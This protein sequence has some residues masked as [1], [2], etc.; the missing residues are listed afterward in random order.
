MSKIVL[1]STRYDL[2]GASLLAAGIAAQLRDRGHDAEAW[3]LYFH[4]ER[5]E[6]PEP[7]TRTF[8]PHEP[9][10]VLDL[11]KMT[12]HLAA[13]MRRFRPDAFFG[14]QPLANILGAFTAIAARCPR[15]YGGQHNPADSQRRTLRALEKLIGSLVYTGNI[16]VSE[17]VRTTY[18]DYPAVYRSKMQVIYNGIPPRGPKQP[19]HDARA[20]LGLP[21]DS[22]LIGTVGQHDTDQKNHDF[23]IDLLPR[24]P[25]VHLVIA[26]DGR[27]H[28][29]LLQKA[30]ALGVAD[31]AHL[32]GSV[33][34]RSVEAVLDALD[35]FVFPSRFE[36]FSL[37][38]LEA[39]Q[40]EL[41]VIGND[42]TMIREA[43]SAGDERYGF[44]IP[45]SDPERWSKAILSLK[46]HPQLQESWSRRAAEGA[47]RFS[48]EKMIRSYE[49]ACI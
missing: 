17:A 38:L 2:G 8:L 4:S 22:F 9:R 44:L 23:L 31:R 40:S 26:G 18:L 11:V 33:S 46:E 30:A 24:V 39:M 14:V 3:C 34:P 27:R 20:R 12:A 41:P 15:R 28:D 37:A 25:G 13:A 47:S 10:G 49:Q 36:G 35:A 21:L 19:K 16:A 5:H 32:L 42:I 6:P 1:L 29:H 43:L 7:W 48:V 45:T